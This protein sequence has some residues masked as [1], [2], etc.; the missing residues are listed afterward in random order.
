M[1]LRYFQEKGYR[2]DRGT[3]YNLI[4]EDTKAATRT[5]LYVTRDPAVT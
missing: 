3:P 1:F 4:A 5:V 2:G